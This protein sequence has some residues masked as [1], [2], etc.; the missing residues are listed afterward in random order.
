MSALSRSPAFSDYEALAETF[1]EKACDESTA[2][3][4]PVGVVLAGVIFHLSLEA[5][6]A[7]IPEGLLLAVVATAS[8]DY[9]S[10]AAGGT[11]AG[12]GQ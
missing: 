4:M 12:V 1:F 8:E 2:S 9:R 7:D 10:L 5:R 6:V 3:G 11:Q